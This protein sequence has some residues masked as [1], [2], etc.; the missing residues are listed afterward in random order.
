M[1]FAILLILGIVVPLYTRWKNRTEYEE[2]LWSLI[3]RVIAVIALAVMLLLN[4]NNLGPVG[5][6]LAILL[7]ST[8]AV[9]TTIK[10]FKKVKA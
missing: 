2:P 9:L 3:I 8:M 4:D 10:I 5:R 6:I 7:C 1:P